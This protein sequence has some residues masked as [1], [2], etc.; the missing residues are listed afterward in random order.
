MPLVGRQRQSWRG[1]VH[2]L[3]VPVLG[4]VQIQEVIC[5]LTSSRIWQTKQST[6]HRLHLI[7]EMTATLESY[8]AR[9]GRRGFVFCRCASGT[10]TIAAGSYGGSSQNVIEERT[11][12][13]T[14]MVLHHRTSL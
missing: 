10:A 2:A 5:Q 11:D 3:G 1:C 12:L 6:T 14:R 9:Q 7:L 4:N 13:S 8:G